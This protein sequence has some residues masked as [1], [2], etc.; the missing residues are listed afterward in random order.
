MPLAGGLIPNCSFDSDSEDKQ[1]SRYKSV[2][3]LLLVTKDTT[4]GDEG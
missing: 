2:A 4:P 3:E 1:E